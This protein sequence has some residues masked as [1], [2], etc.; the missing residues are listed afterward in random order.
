VHAQELKKLDFSKRT[1][2]ERNT[3]SK[4]ML[5]KNQG[6]QYAFDSAWI[7]QYQDYVYCRKANTVVFAKAI[8]NS[9]IEDKIKKA[10]LKTDDFYTKYRRNEEIRGVQSS[11]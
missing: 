3:L 1:K 6:E 7:E 10:C 4:L 2:E 9:P 5:H 11:R 8:D